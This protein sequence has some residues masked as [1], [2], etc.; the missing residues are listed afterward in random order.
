MESLFGGDT[1]T[2]RDSVESLP[3]LLQDW[4]FFE[5]WRSKGSVHGIHNDFGRHSYL[6]TG[7]IPEYY[8]MQNEDRIN[9]V[10]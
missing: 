9:L 7:E 2:V 5:V 3:K 6:K 10:L 4:I 8:H 1:K